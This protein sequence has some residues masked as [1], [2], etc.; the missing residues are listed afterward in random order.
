MTF[1]KTCDADVIPG[2][3]IVQGRGVI[4]VC[5][6]CTSLLA[7]A[8][9]AAQTSAAEPVRQW[10]PSSAGH[11][12]ASSCDSTV[13]ALQARE[14]E[15]VRILADAESKRDELKRV[16]RMLRAAEG[17]N[18]KRGTVAQLRAVK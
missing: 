14:Q 17:S 13:A 3:T 10:S 12:P 9:A 11:V 8:P 4:A 18:R 1:C 16:R 7:D 6:G 15:L 2:A 5:P